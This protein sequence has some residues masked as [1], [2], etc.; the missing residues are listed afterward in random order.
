MRTLAIIISLAALAAC[1]QGPKQVQSTA[2]NVSY[3]YNGES[4]LTEARSKAVEYCRG[5]GKS[6]RLQTTTASGG[7][8]TATFDCV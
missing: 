7:T 3:S 8:S 6:A 4:E 2:P 1:A 5:Y